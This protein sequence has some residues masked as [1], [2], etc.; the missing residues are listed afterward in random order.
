ME[1]NS[2]L[3]RLNRGIRHE[4]LAKLQWSKMQGVARR[5]LR[6]EKSKLRKLEQTWAKRDGKQKAD[7]L[8]KLASEHVDFDLWRADNVGQESKTYQKWRATQR[9]RGDQEAATQ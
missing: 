9:I 4:T 3:V 2:Q 7:W 8:K 5:K 6:G 1:L